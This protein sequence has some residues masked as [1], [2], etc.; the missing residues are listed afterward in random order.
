MS[1][2]VDI[3]LWGIPIT[4]LGGAL[5]VGTPF[6]YVSL[7]ECITEKSGRVNLGLEGNLVLGAMAAF[8]VSHET[9][10]WWGLVIA[11]PWLGVLAAAGVGMILGVLHAVI[12]NQPRVNAVAV[13][14]A[15][16]IFGVG[17]AAY[18]G[19]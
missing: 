10:Q 17:L 11:A 5:R 14:I 8:A 19:K 12:C 15:M 13:G 18:M 7:G 9:N 1:E 3:G 4:V 2:Y 16:M 6:L